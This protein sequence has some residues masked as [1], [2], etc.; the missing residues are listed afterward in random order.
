[1]LCCVWCRFDKKK[2]RK[3]RIRRK[4]RKTTIA[5]IVKYMCDAIKC[6]A[7]FE[8]ARHT[9]K[10]YIRCVFIFILSFFF[11]NFLKGKKLNKFFLFIIFVYRRN[12]KTTTTI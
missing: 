7:L 5:H 8:D 1:V 3:Y 6:D 10:Y 2:K 9:H 11:F 4:A 12:K